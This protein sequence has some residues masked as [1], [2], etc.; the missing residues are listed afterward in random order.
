LQRERRVLGAIP[1][2]QF[3]EILRTEVKGTGQ[4]HRRDFTP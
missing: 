2:A 4:S 3:R 1:T